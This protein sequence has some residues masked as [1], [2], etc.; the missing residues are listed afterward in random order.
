MRGQVIAEASLRIRR[1]YNL[2]FT[3]VQETIRCAR[4]DDYRATVNSNGW[5]S[6]RSQL[7]KTLL[8]F[9]GGRPEKNR[10]L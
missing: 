10:G 4:F 7:P 5:N 8:A 2:C 9:Y 1:R 6:L 3:D